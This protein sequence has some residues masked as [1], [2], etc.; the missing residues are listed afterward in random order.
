[1]VKSHINNLVMNEKE[2]MY[3]ERNKYQTEQK[4]YEDK[5]IENK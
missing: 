1:M 5:I 3:K 4:L 2:N